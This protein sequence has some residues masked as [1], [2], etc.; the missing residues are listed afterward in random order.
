[1][2]IDLLKTVNNVY[3]AYGATDFRKQTSSLCSI[4]RETFGKNPYD[5]SAYIFCNK[6]EI[7]LKFYVMIK[8]VSFQRKRRYWIQ[9][10]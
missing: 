5:N 1:M 8:M 9:I 6:K 2:L 3:L 4:V 7:V 10:R